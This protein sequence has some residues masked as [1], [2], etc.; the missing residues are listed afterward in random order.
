M[1]RNFT[2]LNSELSLTSDIQSVFSLLLKTLR[3][4]IEEKLKMFLVV[5]KKLFQVMNNRG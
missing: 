3:K 4:C 1:H 2:K 5:Y